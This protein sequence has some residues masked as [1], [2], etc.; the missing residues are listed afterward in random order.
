MIPLNAHKDNTLQAFF[1]VCK[2]CGQQ[3]KRLTNSHL[4]R[5]GLTYAA[6]QQ[7]YEPEAAARQV[8]VKFINDFYITRRSRWL[9]YSNGK[10][11]TV[12]N[13]A[14][15]LNDSDIMQ[16]LSGSKGI[17]VYFPE[18]VSKF[19]GLDIDSLD[20]GLL[21]RV[22]RGVMQY[23]IDDCN[24]LM[25][26]SGGKGY[27]VDVFLSEPVDKV[28]INSFYEA[29]LFDIDA[30]EKQVELR[31]GGGQAY[32][33][34]LGYHYKTGAYCCPVDEFGNEIS[35][36]ILQQIRPVESRVIFDAVDINYS[37]DQFAA[38]KIQH[39]DLLESIEL[40][41]SH[42]RT[43]EMTIKQTEALIDAGQPAEG[44]RHKALRL[45]ASYCKDVKSY[46]LGETVDFL[47]NWINKTWKK[48][49]PAEWLRNAE[50]V[51]RS[52][53]K[54]GFI[55]RVHAN[56]ISISLPEIREIFSVKTGNKLQTEALRRLYYIFLLQ[57]KAYAGA[58][59]VFYMSRN[60]IGAM[61]AKQNPIVLQ[62][63][64]E[65]LKKLGKLMVVKRN[66]N[67]GKGN[68]R[69][70]FKKPN[71]YK[72]IQFETYVKEIK[73]T[74]NICGK[75]EKC[76]NC[77]YVALSYLADQKERQQHIKGKPFKQLPKCD[78]NR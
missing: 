63:Q 35:L 20:V 41:E 40:L 28:V 22:Y 55:F 49:F 33:L 69:N 17:G 18:K 61:G 16:H 29:L 6:Y 34:P 10:A 39:E 76:K 3:L 73:K 7:I 9:E 45:I 26:F 54:T 50:T 66:Q 62:Q 42:S 8:A 25:S 74:F 12:S 13:R 77:F 70:K 60:Q 43:N 27:H 72:L 24:I 36:E 15:K 48:T 52:V 32:K 30:T 75:S 4:K 44:D 5:H 31:G 51:A 68:S 14:W 64:I 1:T 46:C 38:L 59:G 58:D 21:N 11:Y 47:K 78:Y 2:V 23:G 65:Q 56:E 67:A 37:P 19:I 71:N 57:S 53:F